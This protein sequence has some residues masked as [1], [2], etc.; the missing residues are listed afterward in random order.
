MHLIDR[1]RIIQYHRER[2]NLFGTSTS[3]SLGWKSDDSQLKRFE[4]INSMADFNRASVLDVGCGYGDLKAFLDKSFSGF[5]YIGIDQMPEFIE[6]AKATYASSANTFFH[7]ADFTNLIFPKVDYVIASG[8]LG[9][10]SSKENF[11]M[12]MI[13]KMFIACSKAMVFNMLDATVFLEHPL[14]TG[15]HFEEVFGFCS[16]LTSHIEVVR[17]YLPDDFTIFMYHADT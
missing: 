13:K 16:S 7:M 10:R 17:G 11:H 12:D 15:H 3:K 1:A 2:L 14:L 9:Y 6:K 4:V 5:T 8:A